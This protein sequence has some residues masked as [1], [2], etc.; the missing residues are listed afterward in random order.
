[1]NT[2]IASAKRH[3]ESL[4][5]EEILREFARTWTDMAQVARAIRKVMLD[6][7]EGEDTHTLAF[8]QIARVCGV[9]NWQ[10]S[11]TN[12]VKAVTDLR[13]QVDKLEAQLADTPVLTMADRSKL[14]SIEVVEDRNRDYAKVVAERDAALAD[15]AHLAR[16]LDEV[17][18]ER[19]DAVRLAEEY[20]RC[21]PP[22]EQQRLALRVCSAD[23]PPPN[24]FG[25]G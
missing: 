5:D 21:L 22:Q 7:L 14:A 3:I 15:A 13:S 25:D 23:A 20:F 24:R 8:E 2:A 1:M 6:A 9:P 4:S 12:V 16:E 18:A 19:E 11:A 10:W 17:R